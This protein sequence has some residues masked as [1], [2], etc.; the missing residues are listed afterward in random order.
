MDVKCNMSLQHRRKIYGVA[1]ATS[2]TAR[3]VLLPVDFVLRTCPDTPSLNLRLLSPTVFFI[4][5][6]REYENG[7][8]QLERAR[9]QFRIVFRH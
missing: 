9:S 5:D 8:W 3:H 4:S 1:P 7:F 2:H 6:P